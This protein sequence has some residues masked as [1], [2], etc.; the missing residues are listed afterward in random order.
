MWKL[1]LVLGLVVL[2]V[3]PAAA[4]IVNVQGQLAKPPEADGI[5]GQAAL[6]LDWREGNNPLFDIGG[7]ASVLVRHGRILGLALARGG[8]GKSRGLT[9]TRRT[10]EHVRAM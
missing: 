3:T 5:S 10:F 7:T 8:Y 4:Q 2:G 9:L 1:C 6:K